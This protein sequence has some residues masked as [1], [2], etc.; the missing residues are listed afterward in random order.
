[1][2]VGAFL[3]RFGRRISALGYS[4]RNPSYARA[5]RNGAARDL[6]RLLNKTWLQAETI[7]TVLD[8]GAYEGQFVK[9]A[10]LLF[11]QASILAFEPNPRLI[12]ALQKLISETGAGTVYEMAC[13]REPAT[14]P[15]HL[16][17]FAPAASLLSPTSGGL[18]DFP[19]VTTGETIEVTV[20]RL[21]ETV[22]AGPGTRKPYLLKIDVQG[23]ELEVLQGSLGILPE[24]AAVVCEV[25]LVP[26]YMG[27]AGLENIHSFMDEN[28]F[29]L[30]DI[31]EPI[32]A[33]EAGEVLYFDVAFLNNRLAAATA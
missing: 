19:T 23:F 7:G 3:E 8:V 16:T 4:W 22:R 29:K 18:P 27:Q 14:R 33:G 28:N 30:V 31:G 20:G 9:T 21:D 32:R 26:F 10:R 1:M 25:N 15:L 13:G 5:R 2:N 17:R 11:P 6:Y 24:V 12:P